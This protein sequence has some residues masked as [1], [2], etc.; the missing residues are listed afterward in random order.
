MAQNSLIDT[1]DISELKITYNQQIIIKLA[2]NGQVP[3]LNMIIVMISD[4]WMNYKKI[5][6]ATFLFLRLISI[7]MHS[8]ILGNV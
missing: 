4:F 2:Y 5:P 1:S 3:Y 6:I 8:Q 7:N